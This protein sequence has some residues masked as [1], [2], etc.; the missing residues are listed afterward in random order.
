MEHGKEVND[1][2]LYRW[3]TRSDYGGTGFI[4]FNLA[5]RLL[6]LGV[7]ATLV[8]SLIPGHGGNLHNISDIA[9]HVHLNIS[10][11]RDEH[12]M[13]YLCKRKTYSS[14]WPGR[15]VIWIQ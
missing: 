4:G 11:V 3:K 1:D 7:S 12:S 14:T 9:P 8:N 10:D 13:K 5:R 6:D 2:P 15:Q